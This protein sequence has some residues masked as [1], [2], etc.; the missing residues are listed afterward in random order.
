MVAPGRP[1]A[2]PHPQLGRAVRSDNQRVGGG[3]GADDVGADEWFRCLFDLV[4]VE[5]RVVCLREQVGEERWVSARY[6]LLAFS[7]KETRARDMHNF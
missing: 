7:K 4:L 5:V 2:R 3:G 1:E 6:S